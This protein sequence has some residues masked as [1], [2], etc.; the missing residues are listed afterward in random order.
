MAPGNRFSYM[1]DKDD[2]VDLG[3][4]RVHLTLEDVE[5]HG[6]GLILDQADRHG[7]LVLVWSE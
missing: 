3:S 4:R 6:P 2:K 1:S 7:N 5:R